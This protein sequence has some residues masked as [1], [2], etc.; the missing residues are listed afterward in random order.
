MIGTAAT[1]ASGAYERAIKK[2]DRSVSVYG[3]SCPLFVPLVEEGWLDG[4]ITREVAG[5]YL[6]PLRARRVDTLILGCTHYPLLKR[7]I[8]SIMGKGVGLIDSAREVAAEAA[9]VLEAAGA[10]N[11]GRRQGRDAFFVSDEPERFIKIGE[12]FLKRKIK[13][14]RRAV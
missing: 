8:S 12:R 13:C 6:R 10:L 11:R 5:I 7:P 2:A 3:A 9:S 4:G 1:I 14:A